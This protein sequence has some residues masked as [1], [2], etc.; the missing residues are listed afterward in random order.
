MLALA[1]AAAGCGS[2]QTKTVTVRTTV[3]SPSSAAPATIAATSTAAPS[4]SSTSSSTST[5]AATV[6]HVAAF[7]SPSGNIGCMIIAGT[8]RCDIQHRSWSPPPR[9]HSCPKIV[10]F[11]QGLIIA[12][13]GSARLVCAGDTVFDPS[14]KVLPYGTD[15]VVGAFRCQSRTTGMTCTNTST[16]DSFSISAQTSRIF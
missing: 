2:S 4:S 14:A 1:L 6:V 8:A 7:R 9:P 11:G 16:G 13:S 3:S 15:T 5:V 12:G 10:D